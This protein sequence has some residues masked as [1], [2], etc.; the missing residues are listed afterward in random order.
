[1]ASPRESQTSLHAN[2]KGVDQPAH[3][4][5]LVSAF[6]FRSLESTTAQLE[7]CKI[8]KFMQNFRRGGGGGG[9]SRKLFRSSTY[10]TEGNK[11]LPRRVQLHIE[12]VRTSISEETH[13]NL[14]FS[15]GTRTP[16]PPSGSAHVVLPSLRSWA[17]RFYLRRGQYETC[18]AKRDQYTVWNG[19]SISWSSAQ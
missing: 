16:D 19:E 11:G 10:F 13:S 2:N 18:P 6:V 12:G 3:P 15:R 5:S 1:M 8:S 4:R 14:W 17:G 7:T 9:V